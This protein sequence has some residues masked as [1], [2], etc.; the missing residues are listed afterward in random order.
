MY[1]DCFFHVGSGV[2]VMKSL[3]FPALTET[4]PQLL[5]RQFRQ[6]MSLND[7]VLFEIENI[8]EHQPWMFGFSR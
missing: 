2:D 5:P 8:L 1:C 6:I 4:L 3:R 7:E